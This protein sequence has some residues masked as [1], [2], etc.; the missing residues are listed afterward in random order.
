MR[1]TFAACLFAACGDSRPVARDAQIFPVD[2]CEH[3]V[4]A[5]PDAHVHADAASDANEASDAPADAPG[6]PANIVN[7]S[8]TGAAIAV[9]VRT[10]KSDFYPEAPTIHVGD[11]IEFEP[12]NPHDV[13][14]GTFAVPQ[15]WFM[16]QGN[17][18]GCVRFDEAGQFPFFCSAHPFSMIGTV[19]VTP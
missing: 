4:D 13:V 2:G 18:V 1:W 14:A 19:T 7:V 8:C 17:T 15:A 3:V 16:V 10:S 6:V 9:T 11:I 12:L 5:R